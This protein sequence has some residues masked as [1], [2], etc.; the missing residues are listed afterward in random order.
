[1][2]VWY[3]PIHEN[4]PLLSIGFCFLHSQTRANLH[5]ACSFVILRPLRAVV[6]DL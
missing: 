2:V 3:L 5:V 1:M 6:Y 4:C